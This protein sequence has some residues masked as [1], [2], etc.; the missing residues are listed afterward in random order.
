MKTA[1]KL[2]IFFILASNLIASGADTLHQYLAFF[3]VMGLGL[4]LLARE[5]LAHLIIGKPISFYLPKDWAIIFPALLFLIWIYGVLVGFY[6]G[7]PLIN[8]IR[9]FAGMAV[10]LSFYL[11]LFSKLSKREILQLLIWGAI[12]N[13]GIAMYYGILFW[14]QN[15]ILTALSEIVLNQGVERT[16]YS[17]GIATLLVPVSI[18]VFSRWPG[19]GISNMADGDEPIDMIPSFWMVFLSILAIVFLTFSKGFIAAIAIVFVIA[20]GSAL[21][22]FLI[23]RSDPKN[24]SYLGLVLVAFIAFFFSVYWDLVMFMFSGAEVSNSMRDEQR[25]YLLNE[26]TWLGRGMGAVLQSGY[27][28]DALGYG[29]EL[30]F[31]NLVHKIGIF[32][33]FVF[34]SYLLVFYRAFINI[35]KKQEVVYSAAALGAMLYIVPSYGNPG[36]FSPLAVVLHC[37]ALYLVIPQR[38]LPTAS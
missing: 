5:G 26:V 14:S 35:W 29:F 32:S 2:F 21:L 24:V 11:F 38:M 17:A 18:Y 9:N 28:R 19:S 12:A 33:S 27:T 22:Q 23:W 16:Y 30:N 3:L 31:E 6:N 4:T 37:T 36:L 13:L 15:S 10:Y 25:L 34:L 20:A 8:I 1:T 7:N